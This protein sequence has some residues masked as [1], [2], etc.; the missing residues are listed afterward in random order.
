[1]KTPTRISF[2]KKL[3][4]PPSG[5]HDA[6][7]SPPKKFLRG[8]SGKVFRKTPDLK[9]QHTP[10]FQDVEDSQF[11]PN[12]GLMMSKRGNIPKPLNL[13]KPISPP[14]SLKKTAGSVASGISKTGQLSTLNS[15]V[16][17]TSS[18]KFNIKGK[19]L[20]SSLLRE[21]IS[22][23][24][25]MCDTFSDIN[26]MV[27]D[28]DY[29]IDGDSYLEEDSPILM[30]NLAR[31]IKKCNSQSGPK[32]YVGEKCLICEESISST[33]TGEKVVESTCSHTSHY[34]CYLMLFETLYFQGKFPECKICGEVSKPKDEDIVPEMV[35][36]LLTGAGAR[37]SSPSS[38]TQQ[39]WI[40]LKSA[41]SLAGRFPLFT[42]QEQL[43]RTAD[44]SCDGFRTPQ[45]SNNGRFETAS[46]LDSPML[47]SP[48]ISQPASAEPFNLGR[49]ELENGGD[50]LE[51]AA[52]AWFSETENANVMINVNF[53]E[54]QGS[55][56]SNDLEILQDVN[57]VNFEEIEEREKLWK[58]KIDQYIEANVDKENEFGSLILFDKIMYSDDGEQ[59][60]DN[61]VVMLFTKFLVLFDFGEM[62]ILGKIPRD[63]FC[64]VIKFDENI[65]LCSLKSTNIPEIYLKFSE[66]CEKWLPAKWKYCL[67]DASLDTLPLGEIVSTVE[68]LCHGNILGALG[69]PFS[70]VVPQSNDRHLPWK[71]LQKETPLKLIV[72]LNLSH[73]GGEQYREDVLETV[74]Q[75]LDDLNVDDLLG[76]VVIGR[77]GSG[78]VGPFGTFIGMINKNWDGW[79]TFLDNLEIVD[80][81][82]FQDEKQEYRITLKT[83]ER[84]AL[85]SAY[86]D[87]NEH[88]GAGYAKQILVLNGKDVCGMRHDQKL[89]NTSDQ[90]SSLWKYEISQRRMVP[91]KA[92]MKQ[93]LKE[94]HS[95]RY[96]NV[97][98]S[99][100]EATSQQL[101][102]GDMA[103]GELKMRPIQDRH[104][105]SNSIEI[106]YF[107]HIKQQKIRKTLE[108]PGF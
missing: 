83:C 17:I 89:K 3:H 19:N 33:F 26:L 74:Y 105:H 79:S 62:R 8:L 1:M 51:C 100:P 90:L 87:T 84:L 14:S 82:V 107:D 11:T 94:L 29:C 23:S 102:F 7:R 70:A 15:P 95:K 41:R 59:W 64:Q 9:K 81:N 68:E 39:Q 67:E 48:F 75:I 31:N 71:K 45:L 22:D 88:G 106:E 91:T 47:S 32:R 80:S 101:Y 63:Q 30:M 50:I 77:D 60:V 34:N 86:V 72:C 53:P 49:D 28:E 104:P 73:T 10:T 37:E 5:D 92:D 103:A 27:M 6:V 58:E 66:N 4:T 40:D 78:Q 52:K 98:C 21:S 57:C 55:N 69:V 24:T 18:N 12:F 20:T 108:S 44:I 42:P 97:A 25:T 38:D 46:Y 56:E 65:L 85:T 43:I 99:L 13:S 76:I 54:V 2:E 96:L 61:S 16:N 36:K 35:S 93:F